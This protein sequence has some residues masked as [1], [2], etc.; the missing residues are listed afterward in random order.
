MDKGCDCKDCV[1][2]RKAMIDAVNIVEKKI[3]EEL[4]KGM[5]PMG[6]PKIKLKIIL[7]EA[8]R[9]IE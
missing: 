2:K 7:D 5:Y 4:R 1:M 8:R 3:D 6:V 9:E